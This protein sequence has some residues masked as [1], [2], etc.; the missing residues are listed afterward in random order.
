MMTGVFVKHGGE[1]AITFLYIYQ[2]L[3]RIEDLLQFCTA[4]GYVQFFT[5]CYHSGC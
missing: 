5:D 2:G 1:A 4:G 3:L